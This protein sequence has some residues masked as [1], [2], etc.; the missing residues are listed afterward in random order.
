MTMKGR[1]PTSLLATVLC[2][3]C[4]GLPASLKTQPAQELAFDRWREGNRFPTIRLKE[5]RQDGQILITYRSSSDLAAWQQCDREAQGRQKMPGAL[6]AAPPT[7]RACRSTPGVG[8]RA[9]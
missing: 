8:T 6:P 4:A 7:T 5:V 1:I 3:A 9:A 2:A